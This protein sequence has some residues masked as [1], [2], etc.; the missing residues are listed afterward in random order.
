MTT[1]KNCPLET[2]WPD[3][4]NAC[5]VRISGPEIVV[6][7]REDGRWMIYKGREIAPG[8]YEL[9][10][11]ENGGTATIHRSG[12]S[13]WLEGFWIEEGNEGMWRIQLSE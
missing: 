9:S 8:H 6:S 12:D 7:Y 5:E 11:A 2:Y 3:E 1:W 4:S 13:E 10:C